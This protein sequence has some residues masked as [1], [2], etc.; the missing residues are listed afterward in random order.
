M[1]PPPSS[2]VQRSV[3]RRSVTDD[4]ASG[5]ISRGDATPGS[6]GASGGGSSPHAAIMTTS[7][8]LRMT[9]ALSISACEWEL[10]GLA[11]TKREDCPGHLEVHPWNL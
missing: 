5:A 9:G 11:H 1:S 4:I 3:G 6:D 8:I 10:T 7:T 2:S